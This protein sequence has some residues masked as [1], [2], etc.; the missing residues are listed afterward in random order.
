MDITTV[1]LDFDNTL[2]RLDESA[3]AKEYIKLVNRHYF[4]EIQIDQFF[5]AMLTATR[6][7]SRNSGNSTNMEVFLESF[8]SM[9]DIPRDD[10]M[11]RFE[12][13]YLSTIFMDLKSLVTPSDGLIE[14]F[15][16]L[17]EQQMAVIIASNPFFP[18]VA[19]NVRLSWLGVPGL[20]VELVTNADEFHSCKPH[21]SYYKEIVAKTGIDPVKCLMVG[22]NPEHD[23]PAGLL[24]MKTYLIT[25][26]GIEGTSKVT[27]M[28]QDNNSEHPVK[29]IPDGTGR[30][31]T[32]FLVWFK[33]IID[34]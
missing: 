29:L 10:S 24:G 31:I 30:D 19:N 13:F 15:R 20:D 2:V 33:S 34:Q 23:L 12:D 6:V 5:K 16:Y 8:C 3:F 28:F 21:L 7:M 22:N 27:T 25:G 32:E 4:P 11:R 17:K 18:A 9:I 1:L 14:L 26:Q